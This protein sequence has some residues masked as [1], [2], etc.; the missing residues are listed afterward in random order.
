M[1]VGGLLFFN[2]KIHT[3]LSINKHYGNL[4]SRYEIM[5]GSIVKLNES[6]FNPSIFSYI[7]ECKYTQRVELITSSVFVGKKNI[8]KL[9]IHTETICELT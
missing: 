5:L 4:I 7:Y 6:V 8:Q 2:L 1:E 3:Y 9:D